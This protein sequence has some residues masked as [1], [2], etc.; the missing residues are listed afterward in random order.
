MSK[1]PVWSFLQPTSMSKLKLQILSTPFMV[2]IQISVSCHVN[3]WKTLGYSKVPVWSYLFE[4]KG[5]A[6][7]TGNKPIFGKY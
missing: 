7:P 6:P 4:V 1:L 3:E 2:K 5:T